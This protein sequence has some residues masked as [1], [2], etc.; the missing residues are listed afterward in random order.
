VRK[1][2][3]AGA[4]QIGPSSVAFTNS[5]TGTVDIQAGSFTAS[6]ATFTTSGVVAVAGGTT[7]SLNQGTLQT[8]ATFSGA[9]TLLA[10]GSTTVNG[11]VTVGAAMTLSG[12]LGG[13]GRLRLAAPVSWEAGTINL[14]GGLD[15]EAGQTLAIASGDHYVSF[16]A[17]RNAGTTTWSSGLL[18]LDNGSSLT[19]QSG[20]IWQIDGS[21]QLASNGNGLSTFTNAGLLKMLGAARSFTIG[22]G[23]VNLTNT[24]TIE[25]RIGG[26]AAGASDRIL[27]Q[28]GVTLGGTLS[29]QLINGFVPAVA[30]QFPLLT[31][32][33][34]TGTFGTI[35]G[36]GHTWATCYASA[37]LSLGDP[38]NPAFCAGP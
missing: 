34:R 7:F 28:S 20:G 17:L 32:L 1:T 19:N 25:L 35:N 26:T 38:A 18:F 37:S 36:N 13:G 12:T 14:N 6:S 33:S 3:G 2:A 31:Y 16:S 24:G 11:D 29:V 22:P 5:A 15:V 27:A 9:G 10:N 8:G 30:D 4:F 21:V 23:G